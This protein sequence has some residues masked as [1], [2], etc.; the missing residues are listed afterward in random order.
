MTPKQRIE[1]KEQWLFPCEPVHQD[2]TA[3]SRH[4]LFG[5]ISLNLVLV[6]PHSVL[7]PKATAMPARKSGRVKRDV[8]APEKNTYTHDL[9]D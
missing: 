1:K 9:D 6:C 7:V 5:D 4:Y 3:N 8:G 2:R